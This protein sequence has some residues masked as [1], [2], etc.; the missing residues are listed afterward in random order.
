ME[1]NVEALNHSG[2]VGR[3]RYRV[4][5]DKHMITVIEIADRTDIYHPG[6]V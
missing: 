6:R 5:D 2:V 3:V 4:G 1:L